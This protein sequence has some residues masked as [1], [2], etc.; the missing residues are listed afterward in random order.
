MKTWKATIK[1]VGND[2]LL[3]PT[4]CGDVDRKFL[5]DFWGL[6]N[7]DVEWYRIEELKYYEYGIFDVFS[8]YNVGRPTY[9]RI[10]GDVYQMPK[11]YKCD[12]Y[13]KKGRM[14]LI[15]DINDGKFEKVEMPYGVFYD[16]RKSTFNANAF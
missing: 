16:Y 9:V 15:D 3:T 5:I 8:S 2:H 10:E 11:D 13:T 12:L 6:K 1:E 7:P 14:K 4:Y